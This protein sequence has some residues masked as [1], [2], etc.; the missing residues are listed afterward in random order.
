MEFA[1]TAMRALLFL[2]VTVLVDPLGVGPAAAQGKLDARYTASLAGIP[3]GRGAWVIDISNGKY[4][5][6][7]SGM[8]VG[9]VR[10][11]ASG[12]GSGAA[13]GS[14]RNGHFNPS[15]YAS[16]IVYDQRAEDLRIVL[17]NGTVKDVSINPQPPPHPDRIPVPDAHRRGVVDPMTAALIRVAGRD[18]PVSAEACQRTIAIFDGRMRYDLKLAFKRLESVRA[19][20]GYE[21]PVVVCAVQFFPMSGYVPHRHSIIYLKDLRDAEVWLAPVAGTRVLVPYKFLL[22][23][24]F[25]L[26][27][28]EATQFVSAPS[29]GRATPTSASV[30]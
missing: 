30:D 8:T 22:P 2:A 17:Q 14:V 5:A 20:R 25:G 28:L 6:A 3:I 13:R 24:S 7:A 21:G 23:T 27:V 11:F 1:L 26:G 9:L 19:H 15:T 29:A 4:V 12:Q 18:D 10:L 16:S